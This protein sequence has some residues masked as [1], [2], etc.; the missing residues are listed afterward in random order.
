MSETD[1]NSTTRAPT[2]QT[3]K[4]AHALTTG[5]SPDATAS[6][7]GHRSAGGTPA[8]PGTPT[9][10]TE[11]AE[12]TNPSRHM[13]DAQ[14]AP[15]SQPVPHPADQDHPA[16]GPGA[17]VPQARSPHEWSGPPSSGR[18]QAHTDRETA[19]ALQH[20][21]HTPTLDHLDDLTASAYRH[22]V[23]NGRYQADHIKEVLG[24]TAEQ[25]EDIT[26]TLTQLHLLKPVPGQPR[27]L[28][29]LSPDAATAELLATTE[30]HI[31]QLQKAVTHTRNRM[32]TLQ[33]LYYES[34]QHRNHTEAFDIITD[35]A[36][37]QKTLN[38]HGLNATKE[39]LTAQPGGPRPADILE[40]ARPR[41][42]HN[43]QR[44]LTIK[45]LYQ[46]TA[47]TDL[48]TVNY[49]RTITDQGAQVRTTD[50]LIDRIIIYDRETV[51]LPEQNITHR[52]PG[53]ALI[54]EPTLVAFLC[55]TYDHLW[56]NATPY[57]P[58][59]QATPHI[60]H[61]LKHAIIKLLAQGHKDENVARKLGMSVR[62][63][64][65]HIAQIMEQANATSR[66]QTG[67]NLAL[68][69]Y[70]SHEPDSLQEG[71]RQPAA[72]GQDRG[73]GDPG[74]PPLE[75]NSHAREDI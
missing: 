53:A 14:P 52:R 36:T 61:N 46:H 60:T 7:V 72:D 22:A 15:R 4:P 34:R 8:A 23:L 9:P 50:Q 65:R 13:D 55:K 2:E 5:L 42:L 75:A 1:P 29:P 58:T 17:P 57:T 31:Q 10:H 20:T 37:L 30:H 43:L 70:I 41:T 44:G 67:A 69:G 26:H 49:I 51:F 59:T 11:G 12:D 40:N 33:P 38:D 66:F 39:I 35:I 62:T 24:L 64:R 25:T 56:N 63:C 74:R 6:P 16:A 27:T 68:A 73:T 18:P 71:H 47:R 54:R 19:D 48:T 3:D 28:I 32:Q 21:L 45:H